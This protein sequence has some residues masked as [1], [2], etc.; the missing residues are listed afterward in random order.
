VLAG[1][2]LSGAV[3]AADALGA[4]LAAAEDGAVGA[5]PPVEHAAKTKLAVATSARNVLV[6]CIS[7]PDDDPFF[8]ALSLIG[9]PSAA[10]GG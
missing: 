9:M 4:L 1:A 2:V 10:P 3:L 5:P 6:R 8:R 7:P